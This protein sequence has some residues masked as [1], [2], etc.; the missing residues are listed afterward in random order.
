MSE[1]NENDPVWQ[2]LGRARP[3][4]DAPFFSRRVVNSLTRRTSRFVQWLRWVAPVSACAG[5]ILLWTNAQQGATER[6]NAEFNAYFDSAA[7]LDNLLASED[8]TTNWTP[9]DSLQ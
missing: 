9:G 6:S 5:A 7:G 2:V 8:V 4:R 3:V 1:W